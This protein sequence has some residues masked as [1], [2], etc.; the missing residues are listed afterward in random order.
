M[1]VSNTEL[2]Y[3]IYV[4][5][6]HGALHATRGVRGPLIEILRAGVGAPKHN[7]GLVQHSKVHDIACTAY[8]HRRTDGSIRP[9]D[10]IQQIAAGSRTML[11]I[12]VC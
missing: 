5:F 9:T 11:W 7:D 6:D 4:Q 3:H 1:S 10:H 8:Q 2:E 12:P